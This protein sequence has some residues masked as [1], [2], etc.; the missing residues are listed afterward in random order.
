[1]EIILRILRKINFINYLYHWVFT[2]KHIIKTGL[3]RGT[4]YDTDI[5][6]LYGMM[7]LLVEFVEKEKPFEVTDYDSD[8]GHRQAALDIAAIYDWWKN[9]PNREKELDK[10]LSEW[11]KSSRWAKAMVKKTT[12]EEF[13]RIINDKSE[14]AA[15]E[16]EL[17]LKHRDMEN[18]LE[19]ETTE[20]LVKLVKLRG[21]LWT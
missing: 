13:H 5:R 12:S 8:D 19:E 9:Y 4:W 10:T 6:L 20:I 11:Y 15:N 14:D 7:S 18:K 1:M 3:N 21:F 16:K 17:L 2:K